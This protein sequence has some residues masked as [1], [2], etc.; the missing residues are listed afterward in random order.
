[1]QVSKR[2]ITQLT[3]PLAGMRI[4]AFH[5]INT[6]ASTAPTSKPVRK[7]PCCKTCSGLACVGRCKF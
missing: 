4:G 7:R 2:D 3:P 6:E 1:M 5:A